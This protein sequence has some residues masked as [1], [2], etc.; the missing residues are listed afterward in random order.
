MVVF[1]L[2]LLLLWGALAVF[3]YLYV[4]LGHFAAEIMGEGEGVDYFGEAERYFPSDAADN[5][6]D[7]LTG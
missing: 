6:N 3:S 1:D 4:R 2:F 5:D 7:S